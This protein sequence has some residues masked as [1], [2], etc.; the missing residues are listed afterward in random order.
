[1]LE[2]ERTIGEKKNQNDSKEKK[3]NER[4]SLREYLQQKKINKNENFRIKE[5]KDKNPSQ[6]KDDNNIYIQS[7]GKENEKTLRKVNKRYGTD[8]EKKNKNSHSSTNNDNEEEK[9][10]NIK[11]RQLYVDLNE[12]E[13]EIIDKNNIILNQR[14]TYND[15]SIRTC[16]YTLLTFLPLALLNQ[17]KTAFNWFFLIYVC[18][19]VN[20]YLSDLDLIPE[21]S[22]FIIVVAIN[23]IKE[24]VEDYRKYS[25]DKKANNSKVIIF[26]DKKFH[27]EKCKN[28]RVGNIIKIY[29]EELIPSDVLIIKSSFK[30]G[31]CYMQTSNLDGENELKPRE[32][33]QITH[34]KIHNKMN[35]INNIF[36]FKD[37]HFFIEVNPPNKDIY[38]IK[39]TVF[40]DNNKNYFS[41]KNVLLRGARLKNVDYVYGI[42][43]YN[44]HDTKLMQNIGHSSMKM[45]NIDKKLNYIIGK[46]IKETFLK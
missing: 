38:D 1:M 30:N 34:E 12:I 16:Q 6:D 19:A 17:F 9:L 23:L 44:G 11:Q 36:D 32:S 4:G 46:I 8:V 10:N 5:Y 27:K 13:D 39:G 41:I 45:S 40:Y 26:K 20:P 15:N 42:V 25:N 22:P 31:L 35:E 7:N 2:N 33:L 37:D 29:K 3:G 43:I 14:R 24:A 28:I 18:I 21:I